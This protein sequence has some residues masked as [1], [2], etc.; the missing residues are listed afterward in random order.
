MT[1]VKSLTIAWHGFYQTVKQ[2]SG[3]RITVLDLE[4]PGFNCQSSNELVAEFANTSN[5]AEVYF[6]SGTIRSHFEDTVHSIQSSNKVETAYVEGSTMG[7]Y[8]IVYR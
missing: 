4:N 7:S 5:A 8:C 1:E 2:S 3:I 6:G